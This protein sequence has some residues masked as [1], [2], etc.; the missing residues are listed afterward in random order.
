VHNNIAANA[1]SGTIAG[2]YLNDIGT[3]SLYSAI[4]GGNDNNI[5]ANS[6]YATIPGGHLNAATNYAFAAGRRAKANHPGAFVWSDS[7]DAD[8]A[9]TRSNQFLLRA[10]GGV[11]INANNPASAVHIVAPTSAPPAGLP[12]SDNGLLLGLYSLSGYK[13]IQ[14]YG[15]ALVLNAVGN[16]V[17]IGKTNPA[18]ALDVNGT[19]TATAFNPASDRNLKENFTGISPCEVLDKVAGLTLTRWNFK[20]DAATPHL[21]PM[22]QDFHAAFGLGTDD[23][24]I[25]TVDADGVALAAIQ[26]LN[27]KVEISG[28]KSESRIQN[29]E[30]ENGELKTR[31]IALE[32]VIANLNAKETG[33]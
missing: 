2:G 29:L 10:S 17:G 13:W 20:G 30:V 3:N 26:G 6:A 27:Q 25:A 31:L 23:R 24:H 15:G 28:Q 4:G 8:F 21:G 14:S 5:A 18:T 11:G 1:F 12:A 32:K 9:S 16:N 19:V 7:Q 22:A 33:R